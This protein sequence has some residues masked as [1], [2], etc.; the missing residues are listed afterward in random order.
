MLY[1]VQN[2]LVRDAELTICLTCVDTV[3]CLW[4]NIRVYAQG[5]IYHLASL[6]SKLIYKVELLDRLAVDCKNIL[7]NGITNLLVS[8][9]HACIY[10]GLR[11][12]AR[13]DSATHL[14]TTRTVN[15]YAM[16]ADNL[17]QTSVI[18]RLDCVVNLV[19]V[20]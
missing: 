10:D 9:A 7:L 11:V 4:V 1:A 18:V 19:V 6:R 12:K 13:L 20:F 2:L 16:L 15:T 5:N 3:V 8:L 14:I 17:Q